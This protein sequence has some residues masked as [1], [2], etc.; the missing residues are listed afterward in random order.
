LRRFSA[1]IDFVNG[2]PVFG[3]SVT[4]E[5]LSTLGYQYAPKGTTSLAPP[6]WVK[7]DGHPFFKVVIEPNP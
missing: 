2:Q 3:W 5:N 1:T 6:N 7:W 4:N